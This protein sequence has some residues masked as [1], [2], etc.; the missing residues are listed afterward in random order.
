MLTQHPAN[1]LLRFALEIVALVGVG[2]W[3]W[4]KF[5]GSLRYLAG[6]GLPLLL[7]LA[8]GA[9]KTP[10]EPG[11]GSRRVLLPIPGRARILFEAVWFLFAVGCMFASGNPILGVSV[12][13]AL[14]LHYFWSAERVVWLWRN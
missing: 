8:W 13:L 14:L 3:A 1:L 6:I 4:Q 12:A 9:F 10:G 7:Y 11:P 5:D 2:Q